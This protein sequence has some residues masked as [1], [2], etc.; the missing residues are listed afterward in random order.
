MKKLSIICAAILLAACANTETHPRP[1]PQYVYQQ[2]PVAQ[3]NVG[4][5]QV[6]EAY[7]M[8][9]NKPNAEQLMPEPLPKAVANW[10]RGHFKATG[11]DGTLTIT[12]K[13]ASVVEQDLK[14]SKGLKGA[15]TIDQAE[16]YNAHILVEFSVSNM[17]SGKEGSGQVNVSRSQSIAENASLQDRDVLWTGMEEKMMLDVDA[18]A[19]T[20][21]QQKLGFLLQK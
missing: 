18:A 6:V 1:V 15:V 12:I 10:A 16:L 17:S 9:M 4:S 19:Q 2:Y 5:I 3:L 11:G 14:R 20:M 21:L 8:P 13:D 7:T